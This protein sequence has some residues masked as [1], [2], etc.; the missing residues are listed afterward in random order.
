MLDG[1]LTSSFSTRF[2]KSEGVDVVIGLSYNNLENVESSIKFKLI[3]RFSTFSRV[4]TSEIE[5]FNMQNDAP[6]LHLTYSAL[7]VSYLDFGKIDLLVERGYQSAKLFTK[8]I[9]ELCFD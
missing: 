7:D 2:L 3:N 9:V 4:L 6:D 1:D 5:R 8:Q